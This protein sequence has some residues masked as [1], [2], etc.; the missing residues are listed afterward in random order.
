MTRGIQDPHDYYYRRVYTDAVRA[1]DAARSHPLVDA[2]RVAVTGGSQGGGIT[3]AVAA[4]S[5]RPALAM[6][7]IPFL[8]DYRR[9]INITPAGT[10]PSCATSAA[11]PRS[12]S[13]TRT[14][15]S[16]ST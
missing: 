15:R 9:A 8:C 4:L 16:P 5:D 2:S 7:D 1:V 3:L 13:V 14:G 6:P 12:R 10:C 11:R